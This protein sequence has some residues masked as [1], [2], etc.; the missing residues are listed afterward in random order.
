[1][2]ERQKQI[3]DNICY[4]NHIPNDKN[5]IKFI[6]H[7]N[8]KEFSFF[9]VERINPNHKIFVFGKLRKK[10]VKDNNFNKYIRV[11]E[12]IIYSTIIINYFIILNY[13]LLKGG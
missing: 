2:D 8:L 6:Q 4:K 13:F 11:G 12:I 9:L 10:F 1:M 3:F 5:K 7:R